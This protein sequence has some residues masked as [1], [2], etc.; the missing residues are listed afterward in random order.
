MRVLIATVL[1][2]VWMI[3]VATIIYL[4][5]AW[6]M[7]DWGYVTVI[8]NVDRAS[9]SVIFSLLL[10]STFWLPGVVYEEIFNP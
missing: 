2:L 1:V 9:M 10:L 7:L 4:A 6:V 3:L 8:D 5:G